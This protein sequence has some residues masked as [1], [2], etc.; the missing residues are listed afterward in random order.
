MNATADSTALDGGKTM[1]STSD[2]SLKY[3][4]KKKT[5]KPGMEILRE[6]DHECS[7]ETIEKFYNKISIIMETM[8]KKSDD[9]KQ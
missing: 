8:K 7:N 9:K 3:G 6:A 4:S 1:Q 5:I 2:D